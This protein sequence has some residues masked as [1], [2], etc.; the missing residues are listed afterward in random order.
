MKKHP[1]IKAVLLSIS[2][3]ALCTL[4]LTIALAG[5]EFRIV[6]GISA[7]VVGTWISFG[8][9]RL[10]VN[11]IRQQAGLGRVKGLLG[12]F[13]S[14]FAVVY[15]VSTTLAI[16]IIPAY[17]DF[18]GGRQI[19]RAGKKKLP[20]LASH[21]NG[22][23]E[24]SA[25]DAASELRPSIGAF[26]RETGR[27]EYASVVAFLKL[28]IELIAV[29]APPDLVLDATND[30]R[31][32]MRHAQNCFAIAQAFD[33]KILRPAAFPVVSTATMILHWRL[34]SLCR[35]GVSAIVD[36]ALYESVSARIMAKM[37]KKCD[38]KVLGQKLKELA[39]DEFRHSAHGWEI[40]KWCIAE[41]GEFV[42]LAIHSAWYFVPKTRRLRFS[43]LYAR[44]G[45]LERYG[46]HQEELE[47]VEYV[48]AF[49]EIQTKLAS[50]ARPSL[51]RS[52]YARTFS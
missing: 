27:T 18:R 30:A 2:A 46:V 22:W 6:L 44:E 19:R 23:D 1:L 15:G 47:N 37:S 49:H 38:D 52:P 17:N 25:I 51:E 5:S 43:G 31:D 4:G 45:A 39:E 28:A 33:G 21:G 50:I 14:F 11:A 26:W 42:M 41:G 36:G 20:L 8:V 10:A 12:I 34:L 16:F 35:I 24:V 29:G 13:F 3:V 40:A 7:C 9:M 48:R 32:E